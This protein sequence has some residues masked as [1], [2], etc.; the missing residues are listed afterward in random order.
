MKYLLAV[1]S[2][3]TIVS[4]TAD[5]SLRTKRRTS[6]TTRAECHPVERCVD[7]ICTNAMIYLACFPGQSE[8][9]LEG[10]KQRKMED[11]RVGDMIL[12][13]EN[14]EVVPTEVLGFLDKWIDRTA[15][16]LNIMLEGGRSLYI[17]RIHVMFIQGDDNKARNVLAKDAFPGDVVIIQDGD[18]ISSAM[19]IDITMEEKRGAYVPLTDAGTL[20]V[21]GVLVSCYTNTDHWLAHT[22]LAPLRWYPSLLLD[23]EYSQDKEGLRTVPG[24][25]KEL[26]KMLGLVTLDMSGEII[27]IINEAYI[28]IM[29]D[30][31]RPRPFHVPLQRAPQPVAF[32]RL[33]LV[34]SAGLMVSTR[35]LHDFSN[36]SMSSLHGQILFPVHPQHDHIMINVLS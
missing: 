1:A 24:L 13:V 26:G 7:G 3:I 19:I 6:C 36:N 25:V 18:K 20:L 27:K 12:T 9:V 32:L 34:A 4:S 28:K 15:D 17:S 14:G 33:E 22:A 29:Q 8:V 16:Y 11:L 2:V 21:D 5:P 30:T 23:N 10:G 35:S 31:R